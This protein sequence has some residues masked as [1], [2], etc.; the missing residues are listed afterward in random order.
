[1]L[2]CE[3]RNGVTL[4]HIEPGKPNQNAH[5]EPFN[6]TLRDELLGQHLFA[7]LD[8]VCE[9][10]LLVDARVQRGPAAQSARRPHRDR[11]CPNCQKLYFR[12]VALTGK[13]TIG[14]HLLLEWRR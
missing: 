4:R 3:H 5:V 14:P 11:I 10:G 2:N 6:R 9:S 1:M 8:D 7:R 12:T 13:L